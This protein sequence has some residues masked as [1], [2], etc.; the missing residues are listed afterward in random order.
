LSDTSGWTVIN[1]DG[2]SLS[3]PVTTPSGRSVIADDIRV[4]LVA[5]GGELYF[6]V[7]RRQGHTS[8]AYRREREHLIDEGAEVSELVPA[9][10]NG[11][12][13]QEFTA[14]F[15]HKTRTF[16]LCERPPWLYRLVYDPKSA[17]NLE[18]LSTIRIE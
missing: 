9:E 16:L 18:V 6:E 14:A 7:S 5:E 2:L 15:P 11:W 10:L 1:F 17:L 12:P 4:H 13:A 8:D 3:H